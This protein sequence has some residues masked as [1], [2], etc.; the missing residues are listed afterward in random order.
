ML[1]TQIRDFITALALPNSIHQWAVRQLAASTASRQR[2]REAQ[3]ELLQ[4]SIRDTRSQMSTVTDLRIRGLIT[5]AEF[6]EKRAD[7][8]KNTYRLEQSLQTTISTAD[9][10]EPEQLLLLFSNKAISWFDSGDASAKR[11]ILQ[12]VGSNLLLKDKKVSIQ[13]KKPFQSITKIAENTRLL[14]GLD[15]V[16]TTAPLS[17]ILRQFSATVKA[18]S[19]DAGFDDVLGNIRT[20]MQRF[21]VR[22]GPLLSG[23]FKPAREAYRF[24]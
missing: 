11:M 15:D 6:T 16:R 18:T 23:F 19:L 3:I 4:R 24:S 1:E 7:L 12:I 8:Q 20:L 17:P 14:A 22:L 21:G 2:T 9:P 5:D 13:A 10:L